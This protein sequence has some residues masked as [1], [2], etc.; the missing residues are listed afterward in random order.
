MKYDLRSGICGGASDH[1]D[2]M[3]LHPVIRNVGGDAARTDVK[4][5]VVRHHVIREVI[6][7]DLTQMTGIWTWKHTKNSWQIWMEKISISI[8]IFKYTYKKKQKKKSK[9]LTAFALL[10]IQER[11]L[12]L[13]T[14][15]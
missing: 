15:D 9:R 10:Q 2:N 13:L 7:L 5:L 6:I 12:I 11:S 1:V 4:P 14:A 8:N 3:D